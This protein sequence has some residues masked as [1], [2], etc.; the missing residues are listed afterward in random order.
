LKSLMD[1]L[2]RE[3]DTLR[4]ALVEYRSHANL[5]GSAGRPR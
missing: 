3:L 1:S 2:Q 5:D 4:Q